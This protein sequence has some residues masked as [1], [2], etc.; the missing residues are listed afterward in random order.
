MNIILY[1]TYCRLWLRRSE[2]CMAPEL[3]ETRCHP[4]D[5][6]SIIT[7]SLC[8]CMYN[9]MYNCEL[10]PERAVFYQPFL[11]SGTISSN[12]EFS[13][14][15]WTQPGICL[16]GICEAR[17]AK[18]WGQR[19]TA[20][21]GFLERG[22]QAL[23]HQLWSL[24]DLQV[25]SAGF[26]AEPQ[27]QMH[28]GLTCTKSPENGSTGRK[29]HLFPGSQF[30]SVEPLDT[31]GRTLRFHGTLVEKHRPRKHHR[32]DSESHTVY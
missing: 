22:Q 6:L 30:D 5:C 7:H 12:L 27:L 26:E 15:P 10:C 14:N 2:L 32:F 11:W 8:M 29:R 21:K 18:I 20:G 19:P 9:Y 31:T 13:Q 17:R 4:T 3:L 16:G 1:C 23:S 24:G 25:P 28:F